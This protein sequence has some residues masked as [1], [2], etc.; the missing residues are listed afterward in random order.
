M[1]IPRFIRDR[2]NGGCHYNYTDTNEGIYDGYGGGISDVV[3]N[4][5]QKIASEV[6]GEAGKNKLAKWSVEK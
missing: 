1:Y 3:K 4:V 2:A 5:G 6:N